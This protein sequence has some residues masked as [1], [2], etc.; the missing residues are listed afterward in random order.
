MP[1]RGLRDTGAVQRILPLPTWRFQTIAHEDF[2]SSS[3]HWLILP[4]DIL[5]GTFRLLWGGLRSRRADGSKLDGLVGNSR[6]VYDREHRQRYLLRPIRS[7]RYVLGRSAS[8][9]FIHEVC[10]A[11]ENHIPLDGRRVQRHANFVVHH[12]RVYN[13]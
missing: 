9:L 11:T 6:A 7:D 8:S 12:I 10:A 5:H 3:N 1:W 4:S 2:L 13:V